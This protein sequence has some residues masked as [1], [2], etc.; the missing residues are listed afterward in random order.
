MEK[1]VRMGIWGEIQNRLLKKQSSV[2]AIHNPAVP[3]TD[4]GM[5][6]GGMVTRLTEDNPFTGFGYVHRNDAGIATYG[7]L[8]EDK[9][10]TM[11][12]HEIRKVMARSAPSVSQA[13]TNYQ[14]YC[15]A[16]YTMLP[17][18]HPLIDGLMDSMVHTDGGFN[19]FINSLLDSFFLHGACFFET[20]YDDNMMPKRMVALD[21]YSAVYRRAENKLGQY[22]ELGQWQPFRVSGGLT[23]TGGGIFKSLHDD[24][25]IEYLPLYAEPNDPYGR[26]FVDS[27]LFHLIMVVGFFKAYKDVLASIVW[28]NLLMQVDREVIQ[29]D[30]ADPKQRDGIVQKVLDGLREALKNLKP[31]SVLAY[32]TEV[33]VG[34]MLSGMNRA[35]LG[36]VED[37]INILQKEIIRGL[38]T[39]QLLNALNDNVTETRARYEMADFAKLISHTQSTINASISRQFNLAFQV[40]GSN[41]TAIF[42][43][44]RSI[45]EE[46][47]LNAEILK[48]VEDAHKAGDDSKMSLLMWLE[49]AVADERM[50]KPEANRY[51]QAELQRRDNYRATQML[52]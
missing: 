52:N 4:R 1:V 7:N 41:E 29:K 48:T 35:N 11:P 13:L 45:Y 16:G 24:P 47:R 25:T 39:N 38:E 30:V 12:V 17:E 44:N 27:A 6:G 33:K 28:P 42:T 5:D 8:T 22:Y 46:D 50:T 51:F 9:L 3:A 10:E 26:S 15:N 43:L 36:G 20:V 23:Q 19:S 18:A 37:F 31:G 34:G 2:P 40:N 32:G 21:P 49:K 14:K